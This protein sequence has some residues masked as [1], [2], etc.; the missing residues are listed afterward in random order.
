M[1]VKNEELA[2]QDSNLEEF[3]A[4]VVEMLKPIIADSLRDLN[5]TDIMP[6]KIEVM[7]QTTTGSLTR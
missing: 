7:D 1:A 4:R 3:R 2:F 5:P 6:H